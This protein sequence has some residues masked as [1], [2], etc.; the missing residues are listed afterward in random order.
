MYDFATLPTLHGAFLIFSLV[1]DYTSN[2]Q[3]LGFPHFCQ[4]PIEGA[5]T[6]HRRR[7]RRPVRRP[8][9]NREA[10]LSF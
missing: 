1:E 9:A 10:I 5:G 2:Q 8:C 4:L 3:D 7:P 6:F